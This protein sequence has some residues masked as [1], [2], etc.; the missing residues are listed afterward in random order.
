ME[1]KKLL[2]IKFSSYIKL[3]CSMFFG[4]GIG[5]GLLMFVIA[6]LG[7]NVYTDLGT[8]QLTGITSGI[9]NIFFAPILA[10]LMGSMFGLLSF[11]PFKLFLRITKGIKLRV[12]FE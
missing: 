2:Q 10:L 7:G 1:E 8:I 5:M 9:V 4:L 11:L 3:S 6:L 12:K